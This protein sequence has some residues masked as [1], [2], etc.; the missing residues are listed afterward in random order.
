MENPS[1]ENRVWDAYRSL[2]R[3]ALKILKLTEDE[4]HDCAAHAIEVGVERRCFD[5]PFL[6]TVMRNRML[7]DKFRRNN[8]STGID[9]DEFNEIAGYTLPTQQINLEIGACLSAIKAMPLDMGEVIR[10]SAMEYEAKEISA[11][12]HLSIGKV[13]KLRR[14]GRQLLREKHLYEIERDNGHCRFIGIF[15]ERRKW[16]A[17]IQ[18]DNAAIYLGL[19]D[20]AAEAARAYDAEARQLGRPT[21][22]P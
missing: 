9:D 16:V 5:L 20:T 13:E 2:M 17:K 15:R 21:N 10:L 7:V 19:F 22:F 18:N 1:D 4:A 14:A 12:L 8:V 11:L 6:Y 3:M